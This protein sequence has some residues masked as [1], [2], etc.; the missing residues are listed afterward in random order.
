MQ[1]LSGVWGHFVHVVNRSPFDVKNGAQCL[2]ELAILS[3][4]VNEGIIS[5]SL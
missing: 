2:I 1:Q 4:L 5:S 3:A